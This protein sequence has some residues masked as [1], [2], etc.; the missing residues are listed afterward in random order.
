M[1]V[2]R[3]ALCCASWQF[4]VADGPD[5]PDGPDGFIGDL[6]LRPQPAREVG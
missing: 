6:D 5:G 4:N 3:A 1:R 2:L